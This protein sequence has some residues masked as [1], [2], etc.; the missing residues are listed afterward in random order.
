MKNTLQLIMLICGF[1]LSAQVSFLSERNQFKVTDWTFKKGVIYNAQALVFDNADWEKV[2]V[3]HTYSMDAI[4]EVGYYK[5]EAWYR[6]N[7]KVESNDNERV[8]IRFEGVGQEAKVYVNGKYVDEHIGGYSA[9]CFDVTDALTKTGKNL[10][11]VKVSNAPNYKRIPVNDV[12]FNHY[13][14]VYRNVSVF[15]APKINIS[16]THHATSGVF[17][18]LQELDKSAKIHVK[19]M[20]NFEESNEEPLSLNYVVKDATGKVVLTQNAEVRPTNEIEEVLEIAKPILWNGKNKAHLY[21]LEVTLKSDMGTDKVVQTFGIRTFDVNPDTGFVLNGKPYRSYGVAMHQEWEQSGPV[22]TKEQHEKDF[23]LI[24]E[25]GATALRMSHYQHSDYAYDLADQTGLLVWAEIPFVHDYSGREQKNAKQQLT[26]LILQNYNHPSTVC[27]GL[28]NEVRA[29][30]SPDEPCV[31]LTKDLNAL[32]HELDLTRKTVSASDRGDES[33]MGNLSDLQAWN[34]YYGWYYG[35][36]KDMGSWLDQY[37]QKFPNRPVGISEYGVGGNIFQHDISK[38]EK[39]IG[40]FFPE[41]EQNTYHEIS[42]KII[43]D[44]PFVFSS[45]IWNMFDFSVAGWNRGGIRNLNHKG[46]VTFDRETKKDAFYFY[47]ANWSEEAVLYIAERRD[48]ERTEET[49]QVKV[50]TNQSKVTLFVNGEMLATQKLTSDIGVLTFENIKLNPGKN[51]IK[52]STG[53][54]LVDEVVW[55]LK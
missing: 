31:L 44:R 1:S 53:K 19:T 8:Y 5:G 12:L 49:V 24:D 50:Y 11:A 29:Y 17:V 9:F 41:Q 15:T 3:P 14:G 28:W 33:N 36:Y 51:T 45:Y 54:K 35:E 18:T 16:P 13:G 40:N 25:I 48:T 30:E 2:T 37:H 39:P 20:V 6:S 42:W 47:K 23:E 46:L 43:Q 10:L 26:E 22:L 27:W 52:I 4:E 55:N 7:F 34:K 32:A 21:N 38:L